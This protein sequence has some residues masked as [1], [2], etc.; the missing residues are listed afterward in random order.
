[1]LN[2]IPAAPAGR[3]PRGIVR[4]NGSAIPGW[5]SWTVTSNTYYEADTFHVTF[6]A[7]AL[8]AATNAAWFSKQ[9]E[10]FVE[11]FAGFPANVQSFSVADLQSQIYG[12][13]DDVE[14]DPVEGMLTLT[15]RDLTAVF[16]DARMTGQWQN[17]KSSDIATLLAKSHRLTPVVTATKTNVGT[18]YKH[19]QVRLQADQS[20]WDLLALLARE[21]GFVCYV[22]GQ[23]LHF[24]PD[25][26]ETTEPYGIHWE[27]P[28][29][30]NASPNANVQELSF[31]RS[32]TV[33]KG[34]VVTV[35]SPSLK[36]KTAVVQSYPS[37][38]KG[39]Q[40][41][42]S[43]PFGAVQNYYF[44]LAAGKTSDD[45]LRYAVAKYGEIIAHEMKLRARLPADNVLTTKNVLRVE[46]TG[47]AFDQIYFPNVITREMSSD[48]GYTM[49]IEA[50][51]HNPDT[52]ATS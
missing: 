52:V 40:A 16:I 23:E 24:E 9:G 49:T 20:E 30:A 8:P 51:N 42:K 6:A 32:L 3:Q 45:V 13:V 46:G 50:K 14:F 43:S 33:A 11:I 37:H 1:M 38:P 35:R 36:T 26:R 39:I 47:T 19:D 41:G 25:T 10:M 17:Q 21:E 5:V 44:T 18:F 12:R 34:V 28:S 4:L 29:A 31:S 22:A 48:T 27:A 15:G 2:T 7:S